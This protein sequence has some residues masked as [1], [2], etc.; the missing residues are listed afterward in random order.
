MPT[1]ADHEPADDLNHKPPPRRVRHEP[2]PGRDEAEP[3]GAGD[4][5]LGPS[6]SGM[7]ARLKRIRRKLRQLRQQS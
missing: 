3:L 5:P 4:R 6:R 7:T 1:A 2:A